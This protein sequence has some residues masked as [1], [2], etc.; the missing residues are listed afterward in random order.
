MNRLLCAL[1]PAVVACSGDNGVTKPTA[2]IPGE[3]SPAAAV[4][5][6]AAVTLTEDMAAP[7]FGSG[8][9]EAAF[10]AF[11]LE[12]WSKARDGFADYLASA[13]APTDPATVAR[14][15]LLIA[16]ADSHLR[17]WDKAAAGFE[18]AAAGL[19]LIAD[20]IN[21]E[22]ARARYFARDMDRALALARKVAADSIRGADAELLAGDILRARGDHGA[23][24]AHYQK[25]IS[26]HPDGI[27]L[28]EA[29]YRLAEALEAAGGLDEAAV[30]YRTVSYRWPH[31]KWGKQATDE[32]AELLP[33]LPEA[34]RAELQR[35]R[36]EELIE[37]G[38]ALYDAMRNP[39]SASTFEQALA[40][41]GLTPEQEC[42][43]RYHLAN[44]WFKERNRTKAAPLF[45]AAMAACDKTDDVDLRVKA[46]YQAGRSYD[47]ISQE[48]IAAKRF[49]RCE[50]IAAEH[51]HS[52]ADDARLRQ[53]EAYE[54]LGDADKEAA[55]L[56]TIPDRY[57]D[58]DMRAEAIWRLA[59]RA[60]RKG[61][62]EAT[63]RWLEKQIAS[64][65]IEDKYY[66]EG[67][68]QYWLG[69]AYG[70]LGETDK[71]VAAYEDAVM[72]YP[73]TYYALLALNR[74]RESHPKRYAALVERIRKVPAD[75]DPKAPAFQFKARELYGEPG[76]RRGIEFLKLGLGW[77]SEAELSRLGL[78]PPDGR[79]EVTDP[80]ER[81]KL[82]AMAFLH[83]NAGRYGPSHW[84][85][86]WHVLDY[87]RSWPTGANRARWEIAYPKA[88][89]SLLKKH[90]DQHGYPIELQIGI[91][92][93][94][95]AFDP[96]RESWANAIG[97]TQ[98]IFPTAVRFGKGTGIEITRENLR[99]PEKNVTIGSNFL[100]F[101]WDKWD[102]HTAL[103]PPSYNA[104]EN[105]VA[106]WLRQR[107][108]LATDEWSE[109]IP[110]DQPR[111]YSKRV[112]S[113]YFVYAYLYGGKIPE[114]RNDIPT[115]II[116]KAR[117]RSRKRGKKKGYG[118]Y[119]D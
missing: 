45:D 59:W 3:P 112:L 52:Y 70:K 35:Y 56:A 19:P 28:D 77:A 76:F 15:R 42:T 17:N 47:R 50:E 12:E 21:Y 40:A 13:D 73:L 11:E 6:S 67:Q 38:M 83:H 24:A 95:S 78:T 23:I 1:L 60:Y 107:G 79:D 39:W 51:D 29:H 108:S 55:L 87:K 81:E 61:D 96:L 97:L 80:D 88:Y 92:R 9:T 32:L 90:A 43:A 105:A 44:S 102:G 58:G 71:S 64:K 4:D 99:D 75:F 26:D 117:K 113:S 89:W 41:P 30:T 57:P 93:E 49:A 115:S 27:R 48:K 65:P 119:A 16:L 104:G 46:A 69:R 34:R 20:Y 72:K 111:R 5:E 54:E 33:K 74:L 31:K 118:N 14:V 7:Y 91:V 85:T 63:V 22:A 2:S 18:K 84:V 53:A 68:P 109:E 82:W 110:G 37:K 100:A 62:Y 86:R 66:A 25:Y 114:M 36:S 101:L 10:R 98:M 103:V 116:P 8:P 94:E 106:R